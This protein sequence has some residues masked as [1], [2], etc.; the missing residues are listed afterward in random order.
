M[1]DQEI[2]SMLGVDLLERLEST[3]QK[4]YSYVEFLM[5]NTPMLQIPSSSNIRQVIT[6]TAIDYNFELLCREQQF[7]LNYQYTK[8]AKGN[9]THIELMKN[10]FI[11]THSSVPSNDKFPR[12]AIFRK[13][14]STSNQLSFFDNEDEMN[15]V[16]LYG[17]LTHCYRNNIKDNVSVF[18]GIPD[19]DYGK[20][21][22]HISLKD[23]SH[24]SAIIINEP[25]YQDFEFEIKK[26]FQEKQG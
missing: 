23:L 25:E 24:I 11:F 4:S 1:N 18:L 19:K 12:D 8:N 20:W 14:L 22:N 2:I 17:I 15:I 16:P 9:H 10:D 5:Q 6:N 21:C 7:N 13:E 3:I 26:R